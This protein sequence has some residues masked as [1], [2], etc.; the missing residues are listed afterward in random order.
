MRQYRQRT[1]EAKRQRAR[2]HLGG[3]CAVCGSTADL[4]FHHVDPDTKSYNISDKVTDLSWEVLVL[5]LD[6]CELRC[7]EHHVEHHRSTA[8][9]GTARRYWRGC[10]CDP[11]TAANTAHNRRYRATR[12][13]PPPG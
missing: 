13:S 4:H 12:S 8:P 5:E 9:H 2:D 10:R 1:N 7:A 11:C 3:A 6:K